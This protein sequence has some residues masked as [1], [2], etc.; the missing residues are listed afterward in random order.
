[1]DL[2]KKLARGVSWLTLFSA[3]KAFIAF[4]A[5]IVLA[6]ILLPEQFGI[7]TL[8]VTIAG[9]LGLAFKFSFRTVVVQCREEF[10]DFVHT[11]FIFISAMALIHAVSAAIGYFVVRELYDPQI[12]I[13]FL[14]LSL[15]ACV[16]YIGNG[17]GGL[18]ERDLRYKA[19]GIIGFGKKIASYIIAIAA[20]VAGAGWWALVIRDL[21]SMLFL[22]AGNWWL[23][24]HRFRWAFNRDAAAYLWKFGKSLFMS[25]SVAGVIKRVDNWV[26]GTFLGNHSLGLYSIGFRLS[27]VA[28]QF[29]EPVFGRGSFGAYSELQKDR[30]RLSKTFG[31]IN[32]WLVRAT[33][34]IGVAALFFAEPAVVGIYG[35]PWRQAGPILQGLVLI[36]V[37]EP[38]SSNCRVFLTA[39]GKPHIVA[40]NRIWQL[41]LTVLLLLPMTYYF[42]VIGVAWAMSLA[43]LCLFLLLLW[44]VRNDIDIEM[45][46]LYGVPVL[47]GFFVALILYAL[48]QFFFVDA[49]QP[50][51]VA[52][53]GSALTC[54]FFGLLLLMVER[55]MVYSQ[56]KYVLSKV[57]TKT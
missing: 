51:L 15:I 46:R 33:V 54:V 32:Y 21:V 28:N 44:H 24:K 47:L 20:A 43:A 3:G 29:I 13:G 26:V 27:G 11:A 41:I 55:K 5:S 49:Y 45:I 23:T 25:R 37:L 19:V 50:L 57:L 31:I 10:P 14:A 48:H 2:G 39:V 42:G 9:L 22:F 52:I 1:M 30:K 40:R 38:A 12:A 18:V 56:A 7:Y 8:G 36:I 34:P 35:E 4:G 6:R 17:L 53:L 16:K